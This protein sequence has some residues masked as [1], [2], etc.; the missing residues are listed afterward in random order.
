[1]KKRVLTFLILSFLTV[2]SSFAQLSQPTLYDPSNNASMNSVYFKLEWRQVSEATSYICQIDTALML[3][4]PAL[5]TDTLRPG[6]FSTRYQ[7]YGSY[8]CYKNYYHYYGKKHYWRV[9]AF[10][11]NDLSQWSTISTY[12]TP[13]TI[14][15]SSPSNGSANVQLHRQLSC[16][17]L[18]G[19]QYYNFQVDTTPS[20]NSPMLLDTIASYGSIYVDLHFNTTYYWR[21]KGLSVKDT[22][23]WSTIWSFSTL[24]DY[25]TMDSPMCGATDLGVSISGHCTS[26]SGI[27][28]YDFQLDTVPTFDSPFDTIYV[29]STNSASFSPLCYGTTY[30]FRARP[31]A[32]SDTGAWS[33]ACSFTTQDTVRL[34]SPYDGNNLG[35]VVSTSIYWYSISGTTR[36][37]YECDTTPAFNSPRLKTGTTTSTSMS[38][39]GLLYG[40]KH[41][42][43]VCA[44]NAIDTSDW[45]TPWTFITDSCP[46]IYTPV[47]STFINNTAYCN[48][49]WGY[50][51][52]S[53]YQW[54][55]DTVPTF[56]SPYDERYMTDSY[57]YSLS[58]SYLPFDR[59]VYW[60][61]RAYNSYG[62]T[63]VWTPVQRIFT[64]SSSLTSP[65]DSTVLVNSIQQQIRWTQHSN[66][67]YEYMWDTTPNFDSEYKAVGTR[68]YSSSTSAT[69]TMCRYGQTYYWTMRNFHSR[70]TST[71][72][73]P[74]R[75]ITP[76]TVSLYSPADGDS[77]TT[78]YAYLECDNIT[79]TSYY[80]F[81]CDTLPT[82]D[83]PYLLDV[84]SY[85]TSY[86]MEPLLTGKKHYWRVRAISSCDTSEW[87][88]VRTFTTSSTFSL[89][90]PADSTVYTSTFTPTLRWTALYGSTNYIYQI[91]TTPNFNSHYLV[92]GTRSSSYNTVVTPTLRYDREYF[93]RVRAV[94]SI[95]TT[96]W[97]VT[98]RFF[99]PK[100]PQCYSPADSTVLTTIRPYLQWTSAYNASRYEYRCDTTPNFNSSY[101]V[102]GN[103]Y[104]T[105]ATCTTLHYD[106][107]YY[108]QV[109]AIKSTDTSEWCAPWSFFTPATPT[110]TYPADS[111][112]FSCGDY[113]ELQCDYISYNTSYIFQYDTVPTFDSPVDTMI[114][115]SNY[116]F[117]LPQFL[118]GQQ[119]YWRVRGATAVDTSAWSVVRT[120]TT[121]QGLTLSTPYD[122][123]VTTNLCSRYFYWNGCSGFISYYEFEIDTVTTF[124]SPMADYYRTWTSGTSYYFGNNFQYRNYYWRVRG[125]NFDGTDTTAWTPYST[126]IVQDTMMLSYP[127]D[128][129]V[130]STVSTQELDWYYISCANQYQYQC[131]TTSTFDSPYLIE[132]T[133]SST[134]RSVSVPYYGTR[135][136]WRV[137]VVTPDTSAW[138][139]VWSFVTLDSCTLSTSDSLKL[140]SPC[141]TFYTNSFSGTSQYRF[142]FDTIATF[143]S[144][145]LI[146][147]VRSTYNVYLAFH[148]DMRYY[149]RVQMINASDTSHWSEIRTFTTPDTIR[150][151]SPAD[152]AILTTLHPSIS[153][154]NVM[155][156]YNT[157]I[158]RID[159]SANFDS[160]LYQTGSGNGVTMNNLHYGVTY[161]WQMAAVNNA[162]DTS[163]WSQMWHFTTPDMPKLSSPDTHYVANSPCISFYWSTI[164]GSVGYEYEADTTPT[165][166]SPLLIHTSWNYSVSSFTNYELHYGKTYYWR[167]RAFNEVDTSNWSLVRDF[168][169]PD[170][171]MLSS[172]ADGTSLTTLSTSLCWNY[173]DCSDNYHLQ[174]DTTPAFNSNIMV[175][176][177]S[178]SCYYTNQLLYGKT[179]YWHVRPFTSYDTA[180]WQTQPWT[181]TTAANVQLTQPLDSSVLSDL[182]AVLRW[183]G[184]GGS[185]HYIYEYDTVPTFNSPALQSGVRPENYLYMSIYDLPFGTTY[186]WR[187]RAYNDIDTSAWTPAWQ[188][189][190]PSGITLDY[191][192]D[193][194]VD[195]CNTIS[196]NSIPSA[197]YYDYKF[198]TT[199]A[200]NSPELRSGTL[201]N[202]TSIALADLHYGTTY[203]WT[204]QAYNA[205][206]S[207]GWC[208]PY[209]FTTVNAPTLSSPSNGITTSAS[210]RYLYWNSICLNT[211]QYE[212]CVATDSNFLSIVYNGTTTGTSFYN[213][214]GY[215]MTYY[216]KV[217]AI[218]NA[219]TSDWSPV[220]NFSTYCYSNN[221]YLET[222]YD[223][224]GNIPTVG[225]Y[226]QW[227]D[228]YYY[229]HWE[230]QYSLNASFEPCTSINVYGTSTVLTDTL[231]GNTTY[232]WRVR[233]DLNPG[234]GCWSSTYQFTTAANFVAGPT[235][236]VDTCGSSYTWHGQ[237]YHANGTY[238]D[239]IS[240]G[241]ADTIYTLHLALHQP[242]TIETTQSA[243]DSYTWEGQ[244]Y[245]A[246]GTYSKTYQSVYGCDSTRVLHLTIY[247]NPDAVISYDSATHTLT[248][249]TQNV[250]Y[251]WLDCNNNYMQIPGA[252]AST[253]VPTTNGSYAVLVKTGGICA[254]VSDCIDVDLTSGIATSG[255][256]EITCYPN[257][258]TASL[259]LSG[260]AG[261]ATITIYDVV[262]KAVC[263][264]Q[265]E[266]SVKELDF[267]TFE[268]G[269]YFIEIRNADYKV[270]KKV[271]KE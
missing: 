34:S 167:V 106:K 266:N 36:Y 232:Y 251:Q 211:T 182:S 35:N 90:S 86:Q 271:V 42:W 147:T 159:T 236:S 162:P 72:K 228:Y 231:M 240:S 180:Y 58:Y 161:N 38:L 139:P 49:Q 176:D 130:I 70:D 40:A 63:S 73:T 263:K 5:V 103:V 196:W 10:N 24:S 173:M 124:D 61:V 197:P 17:E 151:S 4:S 141:T 99:T 94:N 125:V 107:Q 77:L 212:Y 243:C 137:R 74:R 64:N 138:S 89:V 2:A 96:A 191:P 109:R 146:D 189:T 31:V 110:P 140:N 198:D 56:D 48:F 149:W 144:P 39:S 177:I 105:Y 218:S 14:T 150:L 12:T 121:P 25:L 9:R 172:P 6:D 220:W 217:R 44:M 230:F 269:I 79:G 224:T 203:Y 178:Y 264:A 201:V 235:V 104:Y 255:M 261:D 13:A 28:N 52:G 237:T 26:I 119:Y 19:T 50:Y 111:T 245:S 22:S 54:Q 249:L 152:N 234:Y 204:V 78:M 98:W 158:W 15:L 202:S 62:D 43:R 155:S 20:F 59:T 101:L 164:P 148:Y 156:C 194:A 93:W 123:T 208:M 102:Y 192:T 188:F 27:S 16:N 227:Y 207:S 47:D 8:Y 45:Q 108:W 163:K 87:S 165:F 259:Q 186:Y 253:Y 154:S 244:T 97:T 171:I 183:E 225:Q 185:T 254:D 76:S 187:V 3:N 30:Y 216:W 214:Y 113:P 55:I 66:S 1:M 122:S 91:D 267:G 117:T 114:A 41:Y 82:F 226:F 85:S 184:I 18:S 133:T 71:W 51:G 268:N 205:V 116:Y 262:G 53:Y 23:D 128:N 11:D 88:L 247:N 233:G 209:S 175:D 256:R 37:L 270:V 120:F 221:T 166:D 81:Q 160:P 129:T 219:D 241:D 252:T 174:L 199:P 65:A 239:T 238:Y 134:Y 222:P 69:I 33:A 168:T 265:A 136:Y 67:Y 80:E 118:F 195:A 179:Y 84:I 213:S 206:D 143:D 95:D 75:I 181:F 131:D 200:F 242:Y 145:L 21:V 100:G 112:Q 32:V 57:S 193:N 257:P 68:T 250:T 248:C 7:Y 169:T 46:S 229:D 29:R 153:C 260:L 127:A 258:V 246:S 170:T 210:S 132:G 157:D 83:T 142:Q 60:R 126:Y 190:T 135:Y 92:E 223:Y 215:G 115:T